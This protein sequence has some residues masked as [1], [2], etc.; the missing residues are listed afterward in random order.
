MGF[1]A[2]LAGLI[3]VLEGKKIHSLIPAS[4][5]VN[6]KVK[7]RRSIH[8]VRLF[9]GSVTPGVLSAHCVQ[10]SCSRAERINPAQ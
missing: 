4:L 7:P 6:S 5:K 3:I 2:D 10:N 8:T 9:P 1:S